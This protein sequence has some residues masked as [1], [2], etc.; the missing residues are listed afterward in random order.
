MRMQTLLATR[1]VDDDDA[2][3]NADAGGRR[4]AEG[5]HVRDEGDEPRV[6]G[7][8]LEADAEGDDEL[9]ACDGWKKI[10]VVN[11]RMFP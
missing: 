3:A 7:G 1:L 2:D 4:E 11:T 8:Q 5:D 10:V 9:V 6:V